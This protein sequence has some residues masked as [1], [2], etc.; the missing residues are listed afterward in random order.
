MKSLKTDLSIYKK[1]NFEKPPVG[2]K[3][4]FSK[5]EGIKQLD[6]ELSFCEMI[7]EAQQRGTPFY[8]SKENENCAGK[9][10]LGMEEIGPMA[11]TGRIGEKLEIFE[12]GRANANLI[13]NVLQS[14]PQIKKGA[15]N[16]V[17]FAPLDKLTFEPDLLVLMATPAQ[18]EIVLRAMSYK[19]GELVEDSDNACLCLRLASGLPLSNR[20]RKLHDYRFE[21]RH[22]SQRDI[23]AGMGADIHPLPAVTH[24]NAK[25]ERNEMGSAVIYRWQGKVSGTRQKSK[26]RIV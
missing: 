10:I 23:S 15:I 16:Y 20:Q 2:I 22:E 21:L 12:H 4:L 24:H 3:Y 25:P 5:P 18:A 17:A 8:I 26:S 13:Y 7:K 9:G 14:F 6:K 1:F 19:T 11:L